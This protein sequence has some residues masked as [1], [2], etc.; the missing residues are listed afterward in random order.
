M[1]E[2]RAM[3]G[4]KGPPRIQH[5]HRGKLGRRGTVNTHGSLFLKTTNKRGKIKQKK[6]KFFSKDRS[7]PDTFGS[8]GRKRRDQ[9]KARLPL[10]KSVIL[11]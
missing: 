7:L 2:S 11:I 9:K 6:G 4:G 3:G 10:R 8:P 5:I 1:G